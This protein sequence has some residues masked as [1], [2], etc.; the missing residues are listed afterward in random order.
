MAEC[1][2]VGCDRKA[3]HYPII[4][5]T[6]TG[7]PCFK[8]IRM[9]MGLALCR[10]HAHEVTPE[11][12]TD[13]GA[14]QI[15]DAFKQLQLIRPD[16]GRARIEVGRIGDDNWKKYTRKSAQAQGGGRA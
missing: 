14:K 6:P 1:A 16:L 2:R 3:T 5:V 10:S 4:S 15:E 8:P 7:F 11:V 13:Q 12:I 9:A